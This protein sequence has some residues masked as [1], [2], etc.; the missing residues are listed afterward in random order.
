[1]NI[2]MKKIFMPEPY[3]TSKWLII[4]GIFS[5]VAICGLC[6][7]KLF[8]LGGNIS[9]AKKAEFDSWQEELEEIRRKEREKIRRDRERRRSRRSHQSA[10]RRGSDASLLGSYKKAPDGESRPAAKSN[11]S[12]LFGKLQSKPGFE[13]PLEQN[14]IDSKPDSKE[15][16]LKMMTPAQ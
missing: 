7:L 15:Q 6:I 3:I 1:M 8:T 9:K 10:S 4:I 5:A 14:S 2:C 13:E 11:F 12:K 16:K